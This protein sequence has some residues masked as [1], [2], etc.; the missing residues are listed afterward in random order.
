GGASRIN[1]IATKTGLETSG[2]SNQIASLIKLGLVIKEVPITEE[3]NSRKTIYHLEDS[4]FRFWYRF[5][6]PNVS[7]IM[8]G[9]G[10]AIYHNI[11]GQLNDFIG[12]VFEQICIDYLYL[13]DIY[14]ELP[15]PIGNTG[16]WWGN[17]KE[18]KRQEE[19]DIISISNDMILI[20]ECKWT[21]TAIDMDIL[22]TLI[23]RSNLF[24]YKQKYLYLFSKSGFTE[25]V[26]AYAEENQSICLIE[27]D[28]MHLDK[29]PH[30]PI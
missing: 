9:A 20:G 27:F 10:E 11:K 4:M 23:E 16:R 29:P 1:E 7:A 21:N 18:R 12:K 19:I 22:E 6:R 17:N 30:T 2:V 28:K 24:Y 15:F 8:R 5:V 14:A 13:P 26:K 3:K 25:R